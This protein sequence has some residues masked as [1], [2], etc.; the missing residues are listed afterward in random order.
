M[1][2]NYSGK[3]IDW[4]TAREIAVVR[5]GSLRSLKMLASRIAN[6]R[7][8]LYDCME[9][10]FPDGHTAMLTRNNILNIHRLLDEFVPD[11]LG[12]RTGR[13][14]RMIRDCRM[15]GSPIAEDHAAGQ[16]EGGRQ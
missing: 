7:K 13:T 4:L 2:K 14:F 12:W 9:V 6:P 15:H 1:E 16:T 11:P 3:L 5:A 8:A 10:T